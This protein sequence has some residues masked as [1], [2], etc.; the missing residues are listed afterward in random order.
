M[1]VAATAV[2]RQP[3]PG[4][5][6]GLDAINDV[7]REP[8]LDDTTS[9]A[10]DAVVAVEGRGDNLVASGV[11]EKVAGELLDREGVERLVVIEGLDH[12]VAVGP[13]RALRVALE[14]VGVGVAGE[15]EPLGG[16]VFAVM[17]RGQQSVEGLGPGLG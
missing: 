12:P 9:L 5:T 4:R 6:R 7:F 16:H 3:H 8:F 13:H 10:V 1:I 11:R 2:H 14:A 17:G 15:I